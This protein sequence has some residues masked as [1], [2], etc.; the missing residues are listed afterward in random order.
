[1]VNNKLFEHRPVEELFAIVKGDFRKLDDEGLIDNGTLL[2]AIRWCNDKLGVYLREVKEVCITVHNHKAKLPLNFEKLYFA[3][4]TYK[5]DGITTEMYNPLQAINGHVDADV[6]YDAK[7]ESGVIGCDHHNT[8]IIN[9]KGKTVTQSFGSLIPLR[10]ASGPL[11]HIGC[12]NIKMNC[13]N[14][15]SIKNDEI[16]TTF[17]NGEIY[18]MYISTME[19]EKG[20]LLFPFHPLIT[21]YYEWTLKEKVLIDAIFNS[22]DA[23]GDL[24]NK[25]QLAQ[26]EQLKAWLDA[27]NIT[28]SRS[29][30]YYTQLQKEKE[31][32][33]YKDHFAKILP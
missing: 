5:S 8:V 2:K 26:Q 23:T 19:D 11:T 25:L 27:Y 1:M 30:G 6:I 14:H 16:E 7:V 24:A 3:A 32:R 9:R 20:N 13:P 4:A 10:I 29:F 28:T 15:I 21:P 18:M 17:R 31:L 12:P 33:W 22:D